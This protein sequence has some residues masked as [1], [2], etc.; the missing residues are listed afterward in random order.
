MFLCFC[1]LEVFTDDGNKEVDQDEV[2]E[3][4]PYGQKCR[5]EENLELA[6]LRAQ[7]RVQGIGP[8]LAREDLVVR[9]EGVEDLVPCHLRGTLRNDSSEKLHPLF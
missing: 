5:R 8:V 3:Q 9:E 7:D 1:Q 2:R 6:H 4:Q